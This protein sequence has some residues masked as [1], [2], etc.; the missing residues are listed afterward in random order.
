MPFGLF[1]Y[2]S[3]GPGVAKSARR[4]KPFFRFFE[5][6]GRKFWK[7]LEINFIYLVFCIPIV[8]IG[9]ATAALTQVMRKYVLETPIFMFDEFFTAF[10]KNF[11]AS[12]FVGIIDVII[13]ALVG[14]SFLFY[15]NS[16]IFSENTLQNT[17]LLA[18]LCASSA[19]IIMMH[20]YI[21]PQIVALGLP[22]RSILK[23]S[24]ILALAGI[25]GNLVTLLVSIVLIGL[26]IWF[27]P[28][29]LLVLPFLPMGFIA[30]LS[31]FNAYPVITKH[32]IDPYYA[33]R[34]EKNPE[35]REEDTLAAPLFEDMGGREA[36]IK[37]Q[38]RSSGKVIR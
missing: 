26:M 28:M 4:K 25:K 35:A 36:A 16:I 18:L 34:G 6:L 32:I 7:I 11:K 23:N 27:I 5:I 38:P 30:L 17:V 31:V 2:T 15:N 14:F 22:M 29:S 1:D 37:K 24:F 10:K 8:T 3:S 9:P 12:V 20:F 13:I 19:F 33:A 21:Y